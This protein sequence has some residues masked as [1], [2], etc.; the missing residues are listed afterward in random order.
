MKVVTINCVDNRGSTG[1][2]I[3]DIATEL[4][5]KCDFVFCYGSGAPSHDNYYKVCGKLEYLFYYA[6]G[7]LLGLKY[8][9]GYTTTARLMR[10][11]RKQAPD[12]VHIHCPN[13]NVFNLGTILT[14]LKKE[15]IPTVITN[16]AEFFYTGNCPHA[17]DCMKFQT[18]CGSC[19]YVFD[20]RRPYRF[21]RT[22]YEWKRMKK[23]FSG[24]RN[25][26]MVGVS[27]WVCGRIRLS[28]IVP[29]MTP[30]K[31]V[32]N[33][34]NTDVFYPRKEDAPIQRQ[35][36]KKLLLCV[37]S[38]FSN[39]PEDTKG[40][41]YIIALAVQNP[42]I[43]ILVAGTNR[44][45][46]DLPK[47]ITLLGNISDQNA[48]AGLYSLADLTVTTGK[49][50][51]FSMAVAESLCCG[52]P[53]IGFM[54]GGPESITIPEFSQFCEYGNQDQLDALLKKWIDFKN[55][56][57]ADDISKVAIAKYDKAK[58]AHDYYEI[59]QQLGE[60]NGSL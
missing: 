50:E 51:T 25:L 49:R 2:I 23:A 28:P 56:K 39:Y 44:V 53:I 41:K 9:T 30:V 24:F 17:F 12:V 16:H 35:D 37:T 10:Y 55:G 6:L 31:T 8:A 45:I 20:A 34:I 32:L 14:R 60:A 40:G 43:T 11:L 29:E 1:K 58:M 52:T 18:G 47:N 33:G 13:V 3:S 36:D 27:P 57:T 19:D 42:D 46:G 7:R 54:A 15:N 4:H 38:L 21:D 59:Y 48:L 26:V 5:K 22:A